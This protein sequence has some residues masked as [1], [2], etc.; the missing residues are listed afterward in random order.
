MH[1][2]FI[3]LQSKWVDINQCMTMVIRKQCSTRKAGGGAGGGGGGGQNK[4]RGR[5]IRDQEEEKNDDEWLTIDPLLYQQIPE[6]SHYSEV[7]PANYSE[8]RLVE[9][10][11]YSEVTLVESRKVSQVIFSDSI[12]CM[13]T[14]LFMA[15]M[16]YLA[17]D[18]PLW[19]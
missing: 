17:S 11:I 4:K 16:K 15:F 2:L 5:E 13:A 9:S 14:L 12:N 10:R 6:S 8:V 1:V 18:G 3:L 7:R 19:L